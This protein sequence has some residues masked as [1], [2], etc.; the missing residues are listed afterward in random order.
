[1][2]QMDPQPEVFARALSDLTGNI[3]VRRAVVAQPADAV[4]FVPLIGQGVDPAG[5]RNGRVKRRFKAAHHQLVRKQGAEHADRL[6]IGRIVC[7]RHGDISLHGGEDLVCQL[8]HA[9]VAFRQHGLEADGFQLVHAFERAGLF[10]QQIA[11][12][13]PDPV[14]IAGNGE[15]LQLF[16]KAVLVVSIGKDRVIAAD[17]LGFCFYQNVRARHVKELV[18][19]GR[20]AHIAHQN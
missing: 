1:M 14:R 18:F 6:N 13:Q 3:A 9:V 16:R 15:P 11:Q 4:L 7:R 5:Q 19:Q 8:V 17:A 10:A 20:A 2:A 12:K